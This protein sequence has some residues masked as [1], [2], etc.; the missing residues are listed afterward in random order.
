LLSCTAQQ[1]PVADATSALPK[2]YEPLAPVARAPLPPPAASLEGTEPQPGSQKV[3]RSS[4]RW[5]AVKG[6]DCVVVEQAS[7]AKFSVEKCTNEDP[8]RLT[9]TQSRELRGY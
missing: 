5:A 4:P 2:T 8:D 7:Q 6:K 1:P 9:A 3:W